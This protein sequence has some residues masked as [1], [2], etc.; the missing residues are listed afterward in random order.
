MTEEQRRQR[1]KE[2][3]GLLQLFFD[4]P[5]Q[6]SRSLH[7]A[8]TTKK[9]IPGSI[10]AIILSGIHQQPLQMLRRAGSLEVIGLENVYATFDE[11]LAR[12][13]EITSG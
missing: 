6:P 7:F 12:A 5:L 9:R 8:E 11:A 13:R 2:Q 10:T 1:A 4:K 3:V